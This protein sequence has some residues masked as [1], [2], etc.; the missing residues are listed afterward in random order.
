MHGRT[1]FDASSGRLLVGSY[2]ASE[3]FY[4][5]HRV[6]MSKLPQP[7]IYANPVETWTSTE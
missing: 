5:K 7:E 2:V 3:E 1:A 4:S 6:L